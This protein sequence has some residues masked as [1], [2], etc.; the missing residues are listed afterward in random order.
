MRGC[1]H[2]MFGPFGPPPWMAEAFGDSSDQ[3]EVVLSV[4]SGL[5]KPGDDAE[6]IKKNI[7]TA[8]A[9]AEEFKRQRD[10]AKKDKDRE[11]IVNSLKE[12]IRQHEVYIDSFGKKLASAEAELAEQERIIASSGVDR[13]DPKTSSGKRL[14]KEADALKERIADLKER[15]ASFQKNVDAMKEKILKVTGQQSV[16]P[17]ASEVSAKA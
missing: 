11:S 16:Q 6:A 2:P 7:A 10:Q 8:R 13:E 5:A 3:D 12:D 9:Y 4:L 14:V 17:P 15:I 1:W